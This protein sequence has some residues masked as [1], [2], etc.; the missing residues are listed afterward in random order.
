MA[1]I[2]NNSI[3]GISHFLYQIIEIISINT[4]NSKS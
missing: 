4:Y 1:N 3:W 2:P